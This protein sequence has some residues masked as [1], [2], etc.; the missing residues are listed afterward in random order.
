VN[1]ASSS[2]SDEWFRL[3][4][5]SLT[6]DPRIHAYRDD[7]ADIGLAGQ[8]LAPHYARPLI[9]G[10][11]SRAAFVRAAPADNGQAI[12]E[13][14]P[15]EEFAVLEYA[16]GWAWGYVRADHV[17]G[18]VEAIALAE[19]AAATHVVCE[20]CAPVAPDGRI[21]ST[22]IAHLPMGARLHGVEQGACLA[23]EYGC[24]SL[25]H[26]RPIAEHEPDAVRSAERLMGVPWLAGGRTLE[27]IDG[28]GLIQLALGLAGLPAPHFTDQQ[29]RLG[30]DVP[31][32]APS[33]RGDLV[34]SEDGGS[35]MMIDDLLMIHAS[36]AAGKVTV[37]PA[38]SLGNLIRRRF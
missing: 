14:L 8:V 27:G 20:K 7:I 2:T 13:L 3:T 28:P 18:Y 10:C 24:V 19:P 12:T 11:G 33:R 9:R 5:P 35:G 37:S 22:I 6:L 26:L 31:E 38:S 32:L 17:T 21:T 34:F 30:H 4:G 16:G 23:T 25:A 15:G 29:S 1:G 36:R